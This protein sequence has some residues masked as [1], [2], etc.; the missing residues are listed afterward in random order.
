MKF[1]T[2]FR[3]TQFSTADRLMFTKRL[4]FLLGA[5][6]PLFDALTILATQ[7]RTT[8]QPI[9]QTITN[10]VQQGRSFSDSLAQFPRSFPSYIIKLIKAGE[11]HGLLTQNLKY[12]SDEITR[13]KN[14]KQK[15]ISAAVYPI[16]IA[17]GTISLSLF[18]VLI[19]FPKIRSLFDSMNTALPLTTRSIM[20][21]SDILLKY[22]IWIILFFVLCI[23]GIYFSFR[24]FEKLTILKDSFLLS[25]PLVGSITK[26]YILSQFLRTTGIMLEAHIPITQALEHAA[27]SCS[28]LIYYQALKTIAHHISQG[29]TLA[30]C[31]R[32]YLKLFPSM[33]VELI[34]MGETSGTLSQ[35]M[36][37]LSSMLDQDLE[38]HLKLI[39]NLLEPLMMAVMGF[40]VGFIAISIISPIYAITQ[41]LNH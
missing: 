33:V 35:S 13:R 19:I 24:R 34:D 29:G 37:Y 38:E 5:H 32:T 27:E 1:S 40:V 10:N 18:L 17:V 16:C 22:G 3:K 20:L 26:T 11:D 36:M 39:V 30:T 8:I 9:V 2:I 14:L 23:T 7:S 15:I 25:I 12:I 21:I 31:L 4:S 6:M 28:N 41:N